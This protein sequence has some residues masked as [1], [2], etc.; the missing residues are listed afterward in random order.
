[1]AIVCKE[2]AEDFLENVEGFEVV[3]E[4]IKNSDIFVMKTDKPQ[5][6]GM[7][8]DRDYQKQLIKKR[9]GED[10]ELVPMM[11][12]ALPYALENDEVDAIVIDFMKGIHLNGKKEDTVLDEDYT[13]YVLLVSE[14]FKESL[15]FKRFKESYNMSLEDLMTDD[16]KLKEHFYNYTK[17]NLEEG[18]L[19]KWKIKIQFL[20]E[21]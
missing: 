5:K 17:N 14:E 20:M 13:T 2:A 16:M 11:L 19:E 18:G 12:G 1:M 3:S 21:D 9:F 10:V 4:Y 8:Q 7:T 15:E 6:V